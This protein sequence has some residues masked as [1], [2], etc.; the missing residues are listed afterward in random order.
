M[1]LYFQHKTWL[2]L[3]QRAVRS[4]GHN[5][6]RVSQERDVLLTLSHLPTAQ[7]ALF[8]FSILLGC[9]NVLKYIYHIERQGQQTPVVFCNPVENAWARSPRGPAEATRSHPFRPHV[10]REARIV[11]TAPA[12]RPTPR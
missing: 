1:L 9:Y 7:R 11:N 6:I 10:N 12:L 3:N 5:A 4:L 8:I 2:I